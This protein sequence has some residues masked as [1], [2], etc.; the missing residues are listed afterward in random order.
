[1]VGRMGGAND[2]QANRYGVTSTEFI[3]GPT[4]LQYQLTGDIKSP[5]PAEAIVFDD[6]SINSIDDGFLSINYA[7]DYPSGLGNCPSGGRHVQGGVFSFADGHAELWHWVTMNTELDDGPL[8]GT[9]G[10]PGNI[11]LD[12]QRIRY[13]VF[14]LPGQPP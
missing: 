13:D 14:R 10:A 11:F 2:A 7:V 3:L 4:F 1:M 5:G 6:E 8:V 12:A 9:L